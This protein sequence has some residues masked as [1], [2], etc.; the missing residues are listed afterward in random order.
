MKPNDK[1][2]F[3]SVSIVLPTRKR[4]HWVYLLPLIHFAGCSLLPIGYLLPKLQYVGGIVWEFVMLADLPISLVAY[5]LAWKNGLFSMI[6][7]FVAGTLWWYF[8]SQRFLKR[9]AQ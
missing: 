9:R 8:L 2:S 1:E 6:W 3:P 4:S 7:I 5:F